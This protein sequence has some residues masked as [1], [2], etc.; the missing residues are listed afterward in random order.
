MNRMLWMTAVLLATVA[1]SSGCR[2][3][4]GRGD[5][6]DPCAVGQADCMS[7]ITS[8]STI[9]PAPAPTT[10]NHE[11]LPMPVGPTS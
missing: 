7:P 11:V 1:T 8:G 4:G 6:C 3:F 9:L 10:T 2:M 5:R